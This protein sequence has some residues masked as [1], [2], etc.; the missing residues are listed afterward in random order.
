M[1]KEKLSPL[2]DTEELEEELKSLVLYN[3]EVNT[4]DFVIETLIDVCEHDPLQAEQCTLIVHFKGKCGV[5]SGTRD[6][7]KPAYT[8][9]LNRQLTVAIK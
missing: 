7:L 8:E 6:E 5:K 9:M 1:T 3:D 4:F 2:F